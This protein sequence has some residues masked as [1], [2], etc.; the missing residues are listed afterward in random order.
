MGSTL[1]DG[2]ETGTLGGG[3]QDGANDKPRDLPLHLEDRLVF[4]APSGTARRIVEQVKSLPERYLNK[5]E[6]PTTI[7][8]QA[9]P[10]VPLQRP[11]DRCA[12]IGS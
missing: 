7:N 11:H 5:G 2:A 12:R 9:V 8:D 3:S 6:G 10:C 1:K 4:I